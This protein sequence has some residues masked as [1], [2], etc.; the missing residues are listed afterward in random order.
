MILFSS[1]MQV[2][3]AWAI[4]KWCDSVVDPYWPFAYSKYHGQME[5]R[6]G[7]V[8]SNVQDVRHEC[9]TRGVQ[10]KCHICK[11][12]A[13]GGADGL[14]NRSTCHFQLQGVSSENM[15]KNIPT[16]TDVPW[17]VG[18]SHRYDYGGENVSHICLH[19]SGGNC[20]SSYG[21]NYSNCVLRCWG[22]TTPL[23]RKFQKLSSKMVHDGLSRGM[24]PSTSILEHHE[25]FM[26]RPWQRKI[27]TESWLYQKELPGFPLGNP[28]NTGYHKSTQ[29]FTFTIAGDKNEGKA[30]FVDG[31][32]HDAR[33]VV[34]IYWQL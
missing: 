9:E 13:C 29:G 16:I 15:S 1:P 10:S 26:I 27:P 18:G 8:Q 5:E 24:W 22:Y 4:Q 25:G 32:E 28:R 31:F 23:E 2:S 19:M 20:Q 33:Y 12:I 30:G 21:I 3:R 17:A 7:R 14:H 11:D 34:S 6:N